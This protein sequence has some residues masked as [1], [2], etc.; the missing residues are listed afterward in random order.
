MLS[1]SRD[2][3]TNVANLLQEP[4]ERFLHLLKNLKDFFNYFMSELNL[5]VLLLL[6]LTDIM[7]AIS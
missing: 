1:D 6:C 2:L 4:N 5:E 7:L 3:V